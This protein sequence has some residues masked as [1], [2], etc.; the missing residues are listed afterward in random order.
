MVNTIFKSWN[1]WNLKTKAVYILGVIWII[2]LFFLGQEY[3]K[4]E[5]ILKS[6]INE[7]LLQD[8][9]KSY[10]A[11]ARMQLNN[12]GNCIV[13]DIEEKGYKNI[14]EYLVS[15][16]KCW[17]EARNGWITWDIF[18]FDRISK[19]M[20]Y[21]NSP[22][23]MKWWKFRDFNAE[24][25]KEYVLK[26]EE[27]GE[28]FMHKDKNSCVKAIK[29]LYNKWNTDMNSKL[30]WDFDESKEW[31]ESYVIPSLSNWFQ[32]KLWFNGVASKE[33]I[34]LQIVLW[35]QEDEALLNFRYSISNLK[36]IS[37]DVTW[38]IDNVM[39]ILSIITLN[40]WLMY[41]LLTIIIKQKQNGT[42]DNNSL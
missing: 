16:H 29:E 40:C 26:G 5:E 3:N 9:E 37:W 30:Y 42:D 38:F 12:I 23:C 41:L 19:K 36:E 27:K 14:E 34:Q 8:I 25:E 1:S 33:D 31:L 20:V 11:T 6:P 22:D 4:S 21:D 7:I 32:G 13:K 28:C 35:T 18:V 15:I 39:V 10:R 17:S 24:L 2:E